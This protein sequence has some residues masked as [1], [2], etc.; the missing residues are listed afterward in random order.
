MQI[1]N[2]VVVVTG[3]ANGIGR[4]LSRRFAAEKA[5]AVIV[6]DMN[7]AAAHDVAREIGGDAFTV[8]VANEADIVRLAKKPKRSMARSICSAR[9][10]AS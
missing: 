6:A 9:T 7:E 10:P 8:D 4:A 3:G 1:A 5:R 2:K